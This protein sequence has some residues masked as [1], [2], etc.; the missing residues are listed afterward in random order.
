MVLERLNIMNY[1]NIAAADLAFSPQV[2][3]FVGAN[4]MGKSNVL[5]AIYY[6]SFC[7]GFAG[8]Q[9]ALN[10]HHDADFFLLQANYSQETGVK[11][12]VCVSL[13]RSAR[14]RLKVDGM[15]VRRV[16]EHVG[17]VPLVM[18]APSDAA[19]I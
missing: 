18:I 10:V 19:L 14:K 5:D 4:G 8:A 1:R 16:S 3:C 6:L 13:K 15:D 9:D 7:R 12:E 2:N 17:Q 11:R